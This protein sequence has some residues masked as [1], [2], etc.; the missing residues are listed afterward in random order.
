MT[1]DQYRIIAAVLQAKAAS[2]QNE[3]DAAEW[4]NLARAYLRLAEQADKNRFADIWMEYGPKP[5]LGG[6]GEAT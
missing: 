2:E 4:D 1:G 5:T 3:L 6:D